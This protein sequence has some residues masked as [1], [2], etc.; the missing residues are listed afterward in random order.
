MSFLLTANGLQI[1]NVISCGGGPHISLI[2]LRIGFSHWHAR[3]S[4]ALVDYD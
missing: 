4:I 3:S 2:S 1:D